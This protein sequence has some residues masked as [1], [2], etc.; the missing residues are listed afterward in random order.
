MNKIIE[1]K[2]NILMPKQGIAAFGD[3]KITFRDKHGEIIDE[4]N[5]HNLVVNAGLDHLLDSTL[6]GGTQD[7]TWFIGLTDG[8]PT[9]AAADTLASHAGW[10]E[11][12]GYSEGTRQAW[13]AGSVSGQSVDNSAS[14]ARFTANASITVGGAFLAADNTKGGTTGILYAAGAF[15][16]GDRS[17]NNLETI[18][19]TGTFT[20]SS[21]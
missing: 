14:Q 17:L 13:T 11:V 5:F 12:T 19:V 9:V 1:V 16:G 7:T 20:T 8:T 2:P 4:D 3:W 21:S 10:A 15:S 18:D 6:A